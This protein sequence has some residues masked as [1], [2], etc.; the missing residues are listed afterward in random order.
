MAALFVNVDHVFD[1]VSKF[2]LSAYPI[3]DWQTHTP[4]ANKHLSVPERWDVHD[5]SFCEFVLSRLFHG[6]LRWKI[7]DEKPHAWSQNT[8]KKKVVLPVEEGSR[9][10]RLRWGSLHVRPLTC[11]MLKALHGDRW[12]VDRLSIKVESPLGGGSAADLQQQD[13]SGTD[14]ANTTMR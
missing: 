12:G 13:E 11:P 5:P 10:R 3:S 6:Q 4:A 14:G 8:R 7:I 9:W 1:S 2:S